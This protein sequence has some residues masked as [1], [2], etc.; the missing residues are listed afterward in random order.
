MSFLQPILDS[1]RELQAD[2]IHLQEGSEPIFYRRKMLETA[3]L[4]MI[5]PGQ[6]SELIAS[7]GQ[8]CFPGGGGIYRVQVSKILLATTVRLT[9]LLVPPHLSHLENFKQLSQKVFQH[10]TM[11]LVAG[12]P[13]SL[14]YSLWSALFDHKNSSAQSQLVILDR[15]RHMH[16][17][18]ASMVCQ[19]DYPSDFQDW[20]QAIELAI[21]S[22]CRGLAVSD[23]SGK[24]TVESLL[25]SADGT[26]WVM[27]L[28][29]AASPNQAVCQLFKYL[30][31]NRH[32]YLGTA[33]TNSL[34][35][36]VWVTDNRIEVYKPDRQCRSQFDGQLADLGSPIQRWSWH[37]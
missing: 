21:R 28:V 10:N 11:I 19:R 37:E 17:H 33:I 6:L 25:K 12:H 26:R 15:I 34:G 35:L 1:A 18:K 2:A 32:R 9:S 13:Y 31:P 4:P 23:L 36:V 27:G 16:L 22:N 8:L 29:T 30:P 5:E 3:R 7:D 14:T 24:R 20:S